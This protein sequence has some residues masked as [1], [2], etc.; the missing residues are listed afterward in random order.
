MVAGLPEARKLA[1]LRMRRKRGENQQKRQ[2][3]QRFCLFQ[4]LDFRAVWDIV[5]TVS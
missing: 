4:Y 5:M 2:N 3:R 1:F